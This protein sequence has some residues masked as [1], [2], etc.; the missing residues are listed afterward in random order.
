MAVIDVDGLLK[1]VSPE[2]PCG[3]DMEY[4]PL[5]LALQELARGKPEQVIGD[6]VKLAQEP[7]WPSVRDT[8]QQLFA[9]TKDLRVTGI[10]HLALIKT[11]G[12]AGLEAGLNLIRLMLERYWDSLHPLLDAEDDNDPTFRVNSLVTGL[13]SDEALAAVRASPL[14]ESRQFG[15]HSLRSYR[16]ANGTLKVAD[17]AGD[18][19]NPQQE[20]ARIE[21]AFSDAPLESLSTTAAAISAVAEHLNAI[22]HVL[23]DKADGIPDDLKAL[24]TDVKEIKTLLDAQLARRGVASGDINPE[25]PAPGGSGEEPMQALTGSIRNRTDVLT[26]IDKIC[27]YYG[28][29][30]PSSPVPL[31]LQRAKRLVNKDFMEIVRDLTPGGVSE[32]E[33][34]GGLEKGDR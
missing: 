16:I 19:V 23:L 6:K 9:S 33:L 7:A 18:A 14:V 11:E 24:S 12:V 4:E 15:K 34:I 2:R 21:A 1:P 5:F 13:V 8:A 32:A 28:K 26:T 3:P 22:Q 25:N 31:L 17:G 10:L 27:E 29:H 20:L 30:E